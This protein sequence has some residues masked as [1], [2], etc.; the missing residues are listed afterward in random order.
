MPG[1]ITGP[2]RLAEVTPLSLPITH[3]T[4]A[5]CQYGRDAPI[6]S[7]F[8]RASLGSYA[9]CGTANM[10]TRREQIFLRTASVEF[11]DNG[12]NPRYCMLQLQVV[13][14]APVCHLA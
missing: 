6:F 8:W 9:A 4:V 5:G 13:A 10:V 1:T 7:Q 12:Q 2:P 14:D 3:F 11:R